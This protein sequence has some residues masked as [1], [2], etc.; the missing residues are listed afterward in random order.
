MRIAVGSD[1]AGFRLKEKVV[2][3]L[4]AQGHD[5]QDFGAMGEGASVDYPDFAR[6]VAEA[7]QARSV[8][9]GVLLCGSND[10]LEGSTLGRRFRPIFH[11]ILLAPSFKQRA[12]RPPCSLRRRDSMQAECS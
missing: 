7:L 9:L 1:H 2:E 10:V 12:W 8:D 3:H 4:T 5:V 6:H 11:S